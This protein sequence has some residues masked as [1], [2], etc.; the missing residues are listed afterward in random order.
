MTAA[1]LAAALLFYFQGYQPAISANRKRLDAIVDALLRAL[2]HSYREE[3]P[4]DFDLRLNVMRVRR[5]FVVLGPARMKIGQYR[6]DYR[7][8]ELEQ[9]YGPDQGCAGITPAF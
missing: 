3:N 8:A 5:R 9:V 2:E 7:P 4:G 6:G 1:F